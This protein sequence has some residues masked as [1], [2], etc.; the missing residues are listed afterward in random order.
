MLGSYFVVVSEGD[1][2]TH[3]VVSFEMICG[4]FPI[5][6]FDSAHGSNKLQT[7][8]VYRLSV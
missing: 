3:V 5:S 4:L 7:C 1:L 2:E 8:V 6:L